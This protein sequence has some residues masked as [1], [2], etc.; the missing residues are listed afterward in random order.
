MPR[1]TDIQQ[2]KRSKGRFSVYVDGKYAFALGD[3]EL[4]LSNLRIGRELSET[5]VDEFKASSEE[6]KAYNRAIKYLS[7]RPRSVWE[8]KDYLAKRGVDDEVID[9]VVQR[10][11]DARLL[12]DI[13]FAISWV[14]NRQ[15]LRP[16]SRKM[17]E[18]ELQAKRVSR[19]AISVAME[20]LDEEE[21]LLA[22]VGLAE[23]K[24]RLTQYREPEKLMGYFSRQG[25]SYA[26]IKKALER[27]ET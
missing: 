2:Q 9:G 6:G 26:L 4:G 24:R 13:Q 8:V 27:L 10:L 3:L 18:I 23:K 16:R 17:L 7:Y 5:E 19:D 11:K 21:E 20:G 22:L 25:Y 14:V 12:D 1:I 15:A